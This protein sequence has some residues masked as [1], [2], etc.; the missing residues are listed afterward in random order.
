MSFADHVRAD[1]RLRILIALAG[2]FDE[3]MSEQLL[4]AYLK[5][6]GFRAGSDLLRADL[7]VLKDAEAI[8]VS[9][10]EGVWIARLARRGREHLERDTV[11]DGVARPPTARA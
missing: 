9:D 4:A 10:V 8:L 6:F 7:S 1:R 5:Q 3:A 11:I 2:E